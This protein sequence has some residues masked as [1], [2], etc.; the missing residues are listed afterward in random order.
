MCAG[1]GH[2]G[3]AT[4]ASREP[5]AIYSEL[6]CENWSHEDAPDCR[7]DRRLR[8]RRRKS[9]RQEHASDPRGEE[10]VDTYGVME[11]TSHRLIE[12]DDLQAVG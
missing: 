7:V 10:E 12:E 5:L 1:V 6:Q 8:D 11:L 3:Q 4:S 2:F 9:K